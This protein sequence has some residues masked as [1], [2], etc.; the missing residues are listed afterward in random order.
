MILLSNLKLR[1]RRLR[2][3]HIHAAQALIQDGGWSS[4]QSEPSTHSSKYCPQ[5]VEVQRNI[6]A[7]AFMTQN[8]IQKDTS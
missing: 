7:V 5:A 3:T 1:L 6:T 4:V 8:N 2:V